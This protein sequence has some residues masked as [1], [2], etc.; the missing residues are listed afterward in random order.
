MEV[1]K[2]GDI[3]CHQTSF[4]DGLLKKHNL[5]DP[6]S[7][8][9]S[10]VTMP[11]LPETEDIPSAQVLKEIQGHSGEF[12]WLA[13]RTRA[14]LSYYVS[15][16]ASA[17][18]KHA[19]WCLDFAK[20]VLR[21]LKFTRGQGLLITTEGNLMDLDTF[22]YAGFAGTVTKAQSGLVIFWGGTLCIWRSGLQP[23]Y[24]LSTTEAELNAAAQAWQIAE[25]FRVLLVDF[26]INIPTT[27][28]H[29]DNN[30][31]LSILK[32]GA[33]WRTRYFAVRGHRLHQEHELGR[34]KLFYCPTKVDACRFHDEVGHRPSGGDIA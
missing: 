6:N 25:G 20:K 3:F 16:L 26:G 10:T 23:V 19:R 17:Q 31:T 22:S 14:D 5:A 2:N 4:V 7:K 8:G 24:T 15:V 18:T 21:Y 32:C 33:N 30:A 12:N 9:N 34:A 29:I 1:R 13:T 27:R 11:K 28:I